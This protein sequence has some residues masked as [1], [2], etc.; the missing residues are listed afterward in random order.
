MAK[1]IALWACLVMAIV[2]VARAEE[3]PSAPSD[4]SRRLDEA[5]EL[6]QRNYLHE[7]SREQL[8]DRALRALLQDLDPYSYYLDPEEWADRRASLA[9][10]FC[11]IGV[12]IEID[13]TAH[14]PRVHQLMIGSAAGPAGV[15]RADLV[16]SVDGQSLQGLDVD[17]VR[18]HLLGAPGSSLELSLRRDEVD[19]PIQLRIER[20]M[21][22]MPSVRGVRRDRE[23]KSEYMLD[24]ARGIGYVR[25]SRM[26]EDTVPAVEEALTELKQRGMKGLVLDLRNSSGGFAKAAIGVADLFLESG[27]ILTY[28]GRDTTD[29]HEATAERATDVPMVLLINVDTAS[30]SEF[31]AAALADHRRATLVGQRTYGKARM[32]KMFSLAEGDGGLILTTGLFERPSGKAIDRHDTADAPDQAGVWP[33]PGFEVVVEGEEFDAWWK[34]AEMRD[35]G[36]IL[37]ESDLPPPRPDRMLLRALEALDSV[38]TH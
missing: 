31:L 8:L 14:F 13:S 5:I 25:V 34:E 27:K 23:G 33:D 10:Q 36:A 38:E 22:E 1:A 37:E 29:V 20:K 30:S 2:S 24:S 17:R 16:L 9:S 32:Q 21:I 18:S 6:I 7:M 12:T 19:A 26:A 11:G 3:P 35:G 4:A 28:V 15:R